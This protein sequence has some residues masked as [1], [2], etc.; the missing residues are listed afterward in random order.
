[1][2]VRDANG[3]VLDPAAAQIA[4]T[5]KQHDRGDGN[6]PAPKLDRNWPSF[7]AWADRDGCIYFGDGPY[8]RRLT[9]GV[10]RWLR[11]LAVR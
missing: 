5:A 6:R 10:R 11:R 7:E 8:Q 1:M 4:A 2:T 3:R 9:R